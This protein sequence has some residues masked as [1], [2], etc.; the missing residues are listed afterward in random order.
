MENQILQICE[1]FFTQAPY[2]KTIKSKQPL[3]NS[4]RYLKTLNIDFDVV[5][6]DSSGVTQPLQRGLVWNHQQ[7]DGF[8]KYLAFGGEF[9]PVCYHI[10]LN[11]KT[12]DSVVRVID[13]KQR[14]STY[15]AFMENQFAIDVAGVKVFYEDLPK[16]IQLVLDRVSIVGSCVEDSFAKSGNDIIPT[17]DW[18]LIDWFKKINLLGTPQDIEHLNKFK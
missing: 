12:Y 15:I 3:S 14:I 16:N 17:P 5:V 10:R 6:T 1:K 9:P 13:G 11:S 8:I 4:F 18:V 7:K 2:Q